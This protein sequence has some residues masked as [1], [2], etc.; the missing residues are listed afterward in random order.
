MNRYTA[1]ISSTD[2]DIVRTITLWGDT[3]SAAACSIELQTH[4]WVSSIEET[5]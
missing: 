2:T 1:T 4:E 5:N 3:K